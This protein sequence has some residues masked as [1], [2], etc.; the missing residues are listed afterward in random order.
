ML[1]SQAA[2][3]LLRCSLQYPKTAL[4]RLQLPADAEEN[5]KCG[6][7]IAR[8]RWDLAKPEQNLSPFNAGRKAASLTL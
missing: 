4:E 3:I 8:Q 5:I 6:A 2:L 1:L 7:P